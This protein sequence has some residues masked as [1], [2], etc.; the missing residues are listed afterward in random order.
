MSACKIP[1]DTYLAYVKLE[2]LSRRS[3]YLCNDAASTGTDNSHAFFT[4]D[5][6]LK[7]ALI[8]LQIIMSF[9]SKKHGDNFEVIEVNCVEIKDLKL[10]NFVYKQRLFD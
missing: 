3:R 4:Y 1:D 10:D 9:F 6:H 5:K 8:Q 7:K 2:N